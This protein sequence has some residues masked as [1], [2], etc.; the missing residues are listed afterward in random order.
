MA[1]MEA[2]LDAAATGA[3]DAARELWAG[4]VEA[5]RG[6]AAELGAAAAAAGAA[7]RALSHPLSPARLN[8]HADALLEHIDHILEVC[9]LYLFICVKFV[10]Q[11]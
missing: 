6:Q 8:P 5:T 2:E 10:K 4:L 9:S 1:E 3:L 11:I 7:A